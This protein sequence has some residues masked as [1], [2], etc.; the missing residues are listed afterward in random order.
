[1]K[2]SVL[3]K[4]KILVLQTRYEGYRGSQVIRHDQSQLVFHH[5][6]DNALNSGKVS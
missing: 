3:R 2:I 1:M 6:S 4:E 5:F